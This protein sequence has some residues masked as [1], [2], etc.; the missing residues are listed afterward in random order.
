MTIQAE[1]PE[2]RRLGGGL[3]ERRDHHD[4]V[5]GSGEDE[6]GEPLE[7]EGLIPG[8]VAEV[9]AGADQEGFHTGFGRRLLGAGET[10]GQIW[11]VVCHG[12]QPNAAE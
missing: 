4:G 12:C 5:P 2:R 1:V 3:L 9:G 10:V 8:E 6:A 11:C 7:R